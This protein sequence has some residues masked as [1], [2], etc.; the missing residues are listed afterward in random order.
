MWNLVR[1]SIAIGEL[2]TDPVDT[3]IQQKNYQ[4]SVVFQTNKKVPIA[5]NNTKI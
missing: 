3:L 5:A 2:N 4:E 1:D